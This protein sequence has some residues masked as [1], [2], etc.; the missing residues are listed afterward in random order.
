MASHPAIWDHALACSLQDRGE[1]AAYRVRTA[2][3]EIAQRVIL[4][5]I[6]VLE[7]VS[8]EIQNVRL[9]PL[10]KR[11]PTSC[12]PQEIEIVRFRPD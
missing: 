3:W 9:C 7:L 12:V 2:P 6:R 5:F 11:K 1:G 8:A 10:S 4:D